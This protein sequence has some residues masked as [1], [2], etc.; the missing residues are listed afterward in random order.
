MAYSGVECIR[1]IKFYTITLKFS[2]LREKI[3]SLIKISSCICTLYTHSKVSRSI[4]INF[5]IKIII[6]RSPDI[7]T[8]QIVAWLNLPMIN[9]E[10]LFD[11]LYKKRFYE[12]KSDLYMEGPKCVSLCTTSIANTRT[13]YFRWTKQ[14][15]IIITFSCQI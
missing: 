10:F 15:L 4:N 2:M 11:K 6:F 9:P 14:I 7:Y 5:Q 3:L 8:T 13:L 12:S 1:S